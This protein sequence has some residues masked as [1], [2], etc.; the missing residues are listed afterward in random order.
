MKI[1]SYIAFKMD[2]K[3]GQKCFSSNIRMKI[4]TTINNGMDFAK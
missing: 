4:F 3:F 2:G 1:K